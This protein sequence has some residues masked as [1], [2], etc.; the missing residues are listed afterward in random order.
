MTRWP[1]AT[2]GFWLKQVPAFDRMN[3]RRSY[4]CTDGSFIPFL[5]G[6]RPSAVITIREAD[7]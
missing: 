7:T 6:I 4:S 2:T 5:S 1:T 3:L